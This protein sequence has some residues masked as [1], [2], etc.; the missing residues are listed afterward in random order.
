MPLD[1][2][3]LAWF[4]RD[5]RAHDAAALHAALSAHGAVRAPQ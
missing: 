1:S 5:L 4:R 3:A 2:A